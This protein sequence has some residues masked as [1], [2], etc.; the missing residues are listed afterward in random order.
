[1]SS[2]TL[3][4]VVALIGLALAV[5]FWMGRM[6]QRRTAASEPNAGAEPASHIP[7]PE[8]RPIEASRPPGRETRPASTAAAPST[9]P[10]PAPIAGASPG[11]LLGRAQS[12]GYQLQ[13][14][15]VERAATSTF[16]VLVIDYSRDG[17]DESALKPADLTKL[18]R[19]PDGSRRL[20]AAYLSIGEA[21]S[22]RYYWR[23]DWKRR[24]P[25]WLLSENPDWDENYAVCFWDAGWQSLFCGSPEAYLD[26]IIAQGFDGIYLDKCDVTEDLRRR[27]RDAARTR[28]DLDGDMAAFVERLATYARE[29]RPGFLVIMQNAEPLLERPRLRATLDAVAK[30]ELLYGIDGAEKPNSRDDVAWSRERLD[31]MRRDGKPVLVVEYLDDKA[32]IAKA[33]QATRALGYV[34]YVSDKSRE[35]DKLQNRTEVA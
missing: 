18:K 22:Y 32:K 1:M 7:P 24:R 9:S 6:T 27:E 30:E 28:P 5:G 15:D 2:T 29:R 4:L 21:E 33:A 12:W 17:T 16:D 23:K 8:H 13:D 20:V 10:S 14:L 34:L 25:A 35:L 11:A 19:K 31:L 3:L 26:R